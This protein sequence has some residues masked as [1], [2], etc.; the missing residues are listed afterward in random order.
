MSMQC[1]SLTLSEPGQTT[2]HWH[3]HMAKVISMALNDKNP[4]IFVVER[5][6]PCFQVVSHFVFVGTRQSCQRASCA[7]CRRDPHTLHCERLSTDDARSWTM[8]QHWDDLKRIAQ[9][10]L[11]LWT[12]HTMR[13]LIRLVFVASVTSR[14]LLDHDQPRFVVWQVMS[15]STLL[16]Q[17]LITASDHLSKA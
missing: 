13:S 9:Q 14:M 5:P 17:S 15:P 1:W 16:M 11:T 2:E 3:F 7:T 6:K 8:Q 10:E 12:F 4:I